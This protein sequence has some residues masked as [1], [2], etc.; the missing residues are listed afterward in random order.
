MTIDRKAF[1]WLVLKSNSFYVGTE[2]SGNVVTGRDA[3]YCWSA[4]GIEMKSAVTNVTVDAEKNGFP[5]YS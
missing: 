3:A 4:L 2:Q 1:L 5:Q